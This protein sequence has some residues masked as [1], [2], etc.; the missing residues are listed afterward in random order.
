MSKLPWLRSW[1]RTAPQPTSMAAGIQALK[2]SWS[3]TLPMN[4]DKPS[5]GFCSFSAGLLPGSASATRT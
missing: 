3:S 4:W 1:S 5:G 2:L